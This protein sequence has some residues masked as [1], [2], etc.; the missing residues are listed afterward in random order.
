[1]AKSVLNPGQLKMFMTPEEIKGSYS[2][3]D[4]DRG[5]RMKSGY[6]SDDT[7][8]ANKV[9]DVKGTDF[10]RSVQSHGVEHPVPLTTKPSRVTGKPMLAGGHHRVAV[11]KPGQLIPVEHYPDTTSAVEN[12]HRRYR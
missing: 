11:A 3:I 4:T 6:D 2:P 1:M 8:W 12:P 10:E 9:A 5:F 7:V